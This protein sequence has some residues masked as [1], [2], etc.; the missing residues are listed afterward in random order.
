MSIN[1]DMKHPINVLRNKFLS[2]DVK[3]VYLYLAFIPEN[4]TIDKLCEH[5]DLTQYEVMDI[6]DTL[7]SV[8]LFHWEE[9]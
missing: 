3:L 9:Q 5:L 2:R 1:R 6:L 8:N 7:Q 4:V